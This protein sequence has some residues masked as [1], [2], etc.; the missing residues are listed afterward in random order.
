MKNIIKAFV[1]S[2]IFVASLSLAKIHILPESGRVPYIQLIDDAKKTLDIQ[3]YVI[4]DP[5][6]IGALKKAAERGVKVRFLLERNKFK[7][8]N[9][10]SESADLSTL[11][12]NFT[13]KLTPST[14]KQLHTKIFIRDGVHAFVS[15][16]NLDTESFAGLS[17]E[18][19]TRDF[20]FETLDMSIISDLQHLFDKDWVSEDPSSCGRVIVAPLNYRSAVTKAIQSATHSIELYQQD[21]SD[22]AL[23]DL[24]V[25]RAAEG[26]KIS[27][28]MTPYPFSKKSDN[29]IPFQEDIRKNGGLVS[30]KTAPYIH[31]KVLLIDRDTDHEYAFFGSSNFYTSS[32]DENREVALILKNPEDLAA[33]RKSFDFDLAD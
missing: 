27:V 1:F 19:P 20:I 12:P 8:E 3:A 17:N 22:K 5:M 30:L 11:H 32:L 9:T 24:L 15:T 10:Q 2:L 31:A 23:V 28:V 6:I 7:H 4:D 13:L 18:S 26:I 25:K 21:A 29:N 16:G 33:F 14:V